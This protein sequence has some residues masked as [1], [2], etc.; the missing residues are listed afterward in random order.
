MQYIFA[1]IYK[2]RSKIFSRFQ[3]EFVRFCIDLI[4][5]FL[6]PYNQ[7]PGRVDP[8]TDPDSTLE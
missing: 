3:V 8:H 4:N 2:T 6:V 7:D 1:V 5:T